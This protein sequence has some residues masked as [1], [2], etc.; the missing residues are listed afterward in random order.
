M[1]AWLVNEK[2]SKYATVVF[3][4]TR[5]KA[6]SYALYTDACE[7]A[8][9]CNIEARRKPRLDKYYKEG[10]IEMDW[11]NANDRIVLVKELGF[12]CITDDIIVEIHELCSDCPAAQYCDKSKQILD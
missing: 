5:G 1:K 4:E 12:H 10:K 6:K 9:F 3:A 7:D 8:D 11:Y 2:D